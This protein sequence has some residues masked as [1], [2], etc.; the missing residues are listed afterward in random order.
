MCA[1]SVLHIQAKVS[2]A[3]HRAASAANAIPLL[4]GDNLIAEEAALS[5]GSL[6]P[7]SGV[8]CGMRCETGMKNADQ[9]SSMRI[10][11][12]WKSMGYTTWAWAQR[13]AFAACCAKHADNCLDEG[14]VGLDS[15]RRFCTLP[16]ELIEQK[17]KLIGKFD[18]FLLAG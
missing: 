15:H 13:L 14:C 2:A 4:F 7:S 16:S 12:A 6:L 11:W 9:V 18:I 8:L 1:Q 17:G 10:V 5:H 3:A